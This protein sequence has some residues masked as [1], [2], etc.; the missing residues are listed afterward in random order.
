MNERI[1]IAIENNN[2]SNNGNPNELTETRSSVLFS[3]R[4]EEKARAIAGEGKEQS[5][6]YYGIKLVFSTFRIDRPAIKSLFIC[7]ICF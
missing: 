1:A 3:L 7:M 5:D 4:T 6:E 2:N